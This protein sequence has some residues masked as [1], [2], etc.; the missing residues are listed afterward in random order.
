MLSILLYG[1]TKFYPVISDNTFSSNILIINI[2]YF[3][4]AISGNRLDNNYHKV[5]YYTQNCH[6]CV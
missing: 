6:I 1:V 4:P 5:Y 3:Y 2:F